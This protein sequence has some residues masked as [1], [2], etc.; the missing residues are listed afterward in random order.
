MLTA[1]A[2]SVFFSSCTMTKQA[3]TASTSYSRLQ[4]AQC[5]T[6]GTEQQPAH[7]IQNPEQQQTIASENWIPMRIPTSVLAPGSS[8][9]SIVHLFKKKRKLAA[10]SSGTCDEID[11]YGGEKIQAKV[12]EVTETAIKYRK[13]ENLD[14]PIYSVSRS[15]V[16]AIT[17]SNGTEEKITESDKEASGPISPLQSNNYGKLW[18]LTLLGSFAASAIGA[19]II[20]AGVTTASAGIISVALLFGFLFIFVGSLLGIAFLVYFVCWLLKLVSK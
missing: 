13:C 12:L 9:N 2:L 10:V 4:A 17:Y 6:E 7:I 11:L 14:G 1:M 18:I 3:G 5:L 15:D 20:A 8:K 19:A 16:K